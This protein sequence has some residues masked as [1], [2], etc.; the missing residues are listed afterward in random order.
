V[1]LFVFTDKQY[2]YTAALAW[3]GGCCLRLFYVDAPFREMQI[4]NNLVQNP[5]YN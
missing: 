5:G 2:F 1:F 4:N 3:K